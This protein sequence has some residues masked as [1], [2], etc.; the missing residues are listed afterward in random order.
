MSKLITVQLYLA[1]VKQF[2][3][4]LPNKIYSSKMFSLCIRGEHGS[5]SGFGSGRIPKLLPDPFWIGS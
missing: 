3:Q 5:G 1:S 4:E 2:Q